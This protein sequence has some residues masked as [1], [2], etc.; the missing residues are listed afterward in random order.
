M[1]DLGTHSSDSPPPP[2]VRSSFLVRRQ[3][4]SSAGDLEGSHDVLIAT[5]AVSDG[6]GGGGGVNHGDSRFRHVGSAVD[7][8]TISAVARDNN[9]PTTR[10]RDVGKRFPHERSASHFSF[11][12]E[13]DVWG[14]RERKAELDTVGV[15]F[16]TVDIETEAEPEVEEDVEG[17]TCCSFSPLQTPPVLRKMPVNING[18]LARAT[19]GPRWTSRSRTQTK[20]GQA[21]EETALGQE[22]LRRERLEG[23]PRRGDCSG[24]GDSQQRQATVKTQAEPRSTLA[25]P[26][27][28]KSPRRSP[29]AR[30]GVVLDRVPQEKSHQPSGKGLANLSYPSTLRQQPPTWRDEIVRE[31]PAESLQ[32]DLSRSPRQCGKP[33]AEVQLR[34][35]LWDALEQLRLTR[36][37]EERIRLQDARMNGVTFQPHISE[38]STSIVRKLRHTGQPS[39]VFDRLHGGGG[40]GGGGG[41]DGLGGVGGG[42]FGGGG[43]GGSS[44]SSSSSQSLLADSSSRSDAADAPI[45]TDKIA[46]LARDVDAGIINTDADA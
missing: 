29:S 28:S 31:R 45:R 37:Q 6:G 18:H 24:G 42:N 22:R 33:L 44:N 16:A 1:E 38:R 12:D 41:E 43:G 34:I 27:P 30:G 10:G 46:P 35:H 23:L 13:L 15:R 19:S 7:G 39:D 32:D 9:S 17:K 25:K 40:G 11:Q 3:S 8:A 14:S 5:N 36:V 26:L 2:L 20:R 4:R 21:S